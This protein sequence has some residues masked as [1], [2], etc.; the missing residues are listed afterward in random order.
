MEPFDGIGRFDALEVEEAFP[1]VRRQSFSSERTTVS[2]YTFSP[3]AS[4]P[5]HRHPQEQITLV[6]E[7]SVEMTIDGERRA[8]TQGAFSVVSPGVE[9][10][11]TAG[12]DGATIVAVVVPARRSSNDYTISEGR[13]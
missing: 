11:I 2:L 7:G 8:L 12:S 6:E 13:R 1:G 3:Q 5:L 10:G 9:H 4:F